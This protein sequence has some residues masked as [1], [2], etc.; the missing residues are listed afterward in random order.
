MAVHIS[1]NFNRQRGLTDLEF[2]FSSL[3]IVTL[4]QKVYL[5]NPSL[6]TNKSLDNF[7]LLPLYKELIERKGNNQLLVLLS[8][9]SNRNRFVFL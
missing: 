2:S 7:G 4:C 1:F 9:H 8:M 3:Y 5:C 6:V